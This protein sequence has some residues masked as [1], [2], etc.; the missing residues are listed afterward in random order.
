MFGIFCGAENTSKSCGPAVIVCALCDR[1]CIFSVFTLSC[2]Q[3]W[4]VNWNCLQIM[5]ELWHMSGGSVNLHLV[6]RRN[7]RL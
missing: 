6:P 2:T 7:A 1:K 5:K 4:I 3:S